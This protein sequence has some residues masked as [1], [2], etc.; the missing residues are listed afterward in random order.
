MDLNINEVKYNNR[1]R[2]KIEKMDVKGDSKSISLKFVTKDLDGIINLTFD[3]IRII[4]AKLLEFDKGKAKEVNE[5]FSENLNEAN[6][7][8]NRLSLDNY[9]DEKEKLEDMKNFV[10]LFSDL[11]EHAKFGILA[12]KNL[13]DQQKDIND[14]KIKKDFA[15]ELEN[16]KKFDE[17]AKIVSE[18]FNKKFPE[19]RF[20]GEAISFDQLLS[21]IE[22]E[23]KKIKEDEEKRLRDLQ[24]QAQDKK[25]NIVVPKQTIKNKEN[26]EIHIDSDFV[27]VEPMPVETNNMTDFRKRSSK[28]DIIDYSKL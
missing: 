12:T 17:E 10:T 20:E 22:E 18:Q 6:N 23:K 8:A 11:V 1:I 13:A 2:G 14:E 25:E 3:E 9:D 19:K 15:P 16:K 28:L 4:W 24:K 5:H 7:I 27:K 21:K 26:K